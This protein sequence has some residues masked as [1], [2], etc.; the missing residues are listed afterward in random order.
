MQ[1]ILDL[2]DK[3]QKQLNQMIEQKETIDFKDETVS[4]NDIHTAIWNFAPKKREKINYTPMLRK[5]LKLL[6]TGQFVSKE[7]EEYQERYRDVYHEMVDHIQILMQGGKNYKIDAE[8]RDEVHEVLSDV[9]S[10]M[11]KIVEFLQA[12]ANRGQRETLEK[13]LPSNKIDKVANLPFGV[14]AC[15]AKIFSGVPFTVGAVILLV[16]GLLFPATAPPLLLFSGIAFAALGAVIWPVTFGLGVMGIA[17]RAK[18]L[19]AAPQS[20]IEKMVATMEKYSEYAKKLRVIG[21][22]SKTGKEKFLFDSIPTRMKSLLKDREKLLNDRISPVIGSKVSKKD[23][24]EIVAFDSVFKMIA[25]E[26]FATCEKSKKKFQKLEL[27][28][29]D[30][31]LWYAWTDS[32]NYFTTT[33]AADTF[34]TLPT[35]GNIVLMMKTFKGENAI[36]L[37]GNVRFKDVLEKYF[38]KSPDIIT[39]ACYF[40]AVS[41]TPSAEPYLSYVKT[42]AKKCSSSTKCSMLRDSKALFY[43]VQTTRPKLVKYLVDNVRLKNQT[44]TRYSWKSKKE[45]TVTVIDEAEAQLELLKKARE[46]DAQKLSIVKKLAIKIRDTFLSNEIKRQETIVKFLKQRFSKDALVSED[47]ASAIEKSCCYCEVQ[48]AVAKCGACLDAKYCSQEC[49]ENDWLMHE[50]LCGNKN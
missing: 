1:N 40:A 43:A 12:A 41:Q 48:Q 19:K 32:V 28:L 16:A 36:F 38:I 20:S 9:F 22:F 25:Y 49:Q 33:T 37:E 3:R 24:K 4:D 30:K 47:V 8:V 46:V 11:R 15:R 7:K 2:I 35:T 18:N 26:D 29:M 42:L 6:S 14:A 10:E 34:I 17:A 31:A 27:S 21:D 45:E 50:H 39:T 5:L 23:A 44:W 13:F